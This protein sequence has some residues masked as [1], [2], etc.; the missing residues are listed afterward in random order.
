MRND[1]RRHH[2]E[3][4]DLKD[5]PIVHPLLSDDL[6]Q[7]IKAF[8]QILADVDNTTLDEVIGDFKRD[9]HPEREIAVWER[10]AA[11]YTMFLSHNPTDDLATKHD[12]FSVL[13]I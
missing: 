11:T 9:A 12:V 2:V 6:L 5:G 4:A 7:R 13:L 3:L 8:K 10:I 1:E